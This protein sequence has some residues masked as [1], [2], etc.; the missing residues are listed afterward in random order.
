MDK[1]KIIQSKILQSAELQKKLYLWRFKQQRIVFTNGCFDLLHRGHVHLLSHAAALGDVLIVGLNS[2]ASVRQ[3]KG[4]NRPLQDEETRA[5][6][7]ASLFYVHAVVLF[8]EETPVELIK[9]IQ[10]DVLV[11]GSDYKNRKIA[12]AEYVQQQGGRVEFVDLLPGYSTTALT[13]RI[14][15]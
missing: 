8:Q 4:S 12:G 9:L 6:V 10:P 15:G 3:L 11:K 7:L 5:W 1:T 13:Q 14:S 2:D